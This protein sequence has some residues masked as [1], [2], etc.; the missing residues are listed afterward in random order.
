[1][2]VRLPSLFISR[3]GHCSCLRC[4]CRPHSRWQLQLQ[5]FVMRVVLVRVAAAAAAVVSSGGGQVE[6]F[7]KLGSFTVV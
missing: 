6:V 2:L 1:M 7:V 3:C 5:P 4:G